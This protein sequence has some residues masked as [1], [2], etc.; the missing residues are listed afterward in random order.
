MFR[1]APVLPVVS[2]QKVEIVY[3]HN[4]ETLSLDLPQKKGV[5]I[6]EKPLMRGEI[7]QLSQNDGFDTVDEFFEYF[8]EDFTGKLIHW[9]DFKY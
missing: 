7:E 8:N 9:T 1:F 3:Y 6:D 2:V 4:R 5:I